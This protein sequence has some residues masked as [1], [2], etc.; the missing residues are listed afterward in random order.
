MGEP[1]G[2]NSLWGKEGK[3]ERKGVFRSHRREERRKKLNPSF[4]WRQSRIK[5][6]QGK[7]RGGRGSPRRPKGV[8][9]GRDREGVQKGEEGGLRGRGR[10]GW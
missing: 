5:Y 3:K 10:V 4:A 1:F 7:K 8:G 2:P 6:C 9:K